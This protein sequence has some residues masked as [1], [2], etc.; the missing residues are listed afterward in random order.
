MA[1]SNALAFFGGVTRLSGSAVGLKA[2]VEQFAGEPVNISAIY[3]SFRWAWLDRIHFDVFQH[4]WSVEIENESK[5]LYRLVS[6]KFES[7]ADRIT[8]IRQRLRPVYHDCVHG[9]RDVNTEFCLFNTASAALSISEVLK[10]VAAHEDARGSSYDRILLS[11]P[12]LVFTQ[13]PPLFTDT[14]YPRHEVAVEYLGIKSLRGFPDTIFVLPTSSAARRMSRIFY[15]LQ[16]NVT[17]R[18]GWVATFIS[19]E[20]TPNVW[21]VERLR[22]VDISR[23]LCSRTLAS[24][25]PTGRTDHD[26]VTADLFSIIQSWGF[27]C[28]YLRRFP[29][30]NDPYASRCCTMCKACPKLTNAS[31]T[32]HGLNTV[33]QA[34]QWA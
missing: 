14:H 11:R 9:M 22:G 33:R 17:Y 27:S 16:P 19:A 24:Q 10:L 28:D 13:Q 25:T 29:R 12:D 7:N 3:S 32:M 5:A 6:W 23:R 30:F 8:D 31:N 4:S 2:G 1:A 21:P 34:K 26:Q 15:Y 20:V 18:W